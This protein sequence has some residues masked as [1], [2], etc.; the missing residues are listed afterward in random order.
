MADLL[1]TCPWTTWLCTEST[2]PD[3]AAERRR[4]QL[5]HRPVHGGEMM[6]RC[7]RSGSELDLHVLDLTTLL[8]LAQLEPR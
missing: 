8:P 3:I 2:R 5:L 1:P 4:N 7:E 6:A